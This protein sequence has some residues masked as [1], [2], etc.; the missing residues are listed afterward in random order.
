MKKTKKIL[1]L[2]IFIA[3]ISLGVG[4]SAIQNI[5]LDIKGI[6][7]ANTSEK[8]LIKGIE[9]NKLLKGVTNEWTEDTKIAK[10]I[11][12]Y[13]NDGYIEDG[14]T[15]FEDSDWYNGTSIDEAGKGGIKLFRSDDGTVA[16]ILSEDVIYAHSNCNKI[17]LNFRNVTEIVF[18]NFNTSKVQ[19]MNGLFFQCK[20]LPDIDVSGFDTSNVTEMG[21]M[22]FD[23]FA[24]KKLDLSNFD[25][26]NVTN[27]SYM[28]AWCGNLSEIDLTSFNTSKVTTMKE[29]FA[30]CNAYKNID[31]GNFDTSNVTNME[32][33]FSYCYFTNI[34]LSNFDT[35]N[36][37]N[38]MAMFANNYKVTTI[39]VSDK[40][41]T[42]K[43][44]QTNETDEYQ[45]FYG[46]SRLVGGAGTAYNS[47]NIDISYA[48]IDGGPDSDTPGYLT[49]K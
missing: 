33:M 22:F 11:F 46:D 13:W 37:T 12:D 48:R 27:M 47:N 23:N 39:Y 24:L 21:N 34:D 9:F 35:S 20:K 49:K 8:T 38:M 16:Y 28:F 43:V 42:E 40:W 30:G 45:P 5:T 26:S 32:R 2:I 6:A 31:L 15:I 7:V 18:N 41:T 36:V 4:Y 1:I 19:N 14:N 17:F 29:M 25:T 10:I 3:I 44:I